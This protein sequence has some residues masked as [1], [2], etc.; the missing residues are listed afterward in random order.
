M[1][2]ILL[3]WETKLTDVYKIQNSFNILKCDYVFWVILVSN[4]SNDSKYMK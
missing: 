2:F 3:F 4:L 1:I